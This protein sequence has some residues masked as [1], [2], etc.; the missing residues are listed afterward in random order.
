MQKLDYD[1]TL[2][3]FKHHLQLCSSHLLS[4]ST[5][6]P[7][8]SIT[9]TKLPSTSRVTRVSSSPLSAAWALWPLLTPRI[10][11]V[12]GCLLLTRLGL[13]PQLH[14][15]SSQLATSTSVSS[16]PGPRQLVL[17]WSTSLDRSAS[18]LPGSG[19]WSAQPWRHQVYMGC[20][21]SSAHPCSFPGQ[22]CA[23]RGRKCP[24]KAHSQA[25][26]ERRVNLH[27]LYIMT[28]HDNDSI[29]Q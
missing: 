25:C 14:L 2:K 17:H 13:L 3:D 18:S 12:P 8:S 7:S 15:C 27:H 23:Q 11:C 1:T 10:S 22:L 4:I 19:L 6:C 29:G 24:S 26:R 20:W 21:K 5:P 9:S 28:M 16:L